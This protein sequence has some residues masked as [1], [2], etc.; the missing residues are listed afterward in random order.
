MRDNESIKGIILGCTE[1]PLILA[2]EAYEGIPYLNTK[3][4][5]IDAIADSWL[6]N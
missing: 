2:E 4:S 3:A 1:L 6:H 5:R